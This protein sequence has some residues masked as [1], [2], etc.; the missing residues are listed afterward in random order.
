MRIDKKTAAFLLAVLD[1]RPAIVRRFREEGRTSEAD[2]IE[3]A[4]WHLKRKLDE[5]STD[6]RFNT[7][8]ATTAQNAEHVTK[9]LCRSGDNRG[10][11][12]PYFD[13]IEGSQEEGPGRSGEGGLLLNLLI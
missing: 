9:R 1:S 11:R 4:I 10:G 6:N 3:D 2:R 8:W 12:R 7:D 13:K 5:Y